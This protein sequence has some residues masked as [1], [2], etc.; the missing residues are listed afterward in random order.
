MLSAA[1]CILVYSDEQLAKTEDC[2]N[3]GYDLRQ[4]NATRRQQ[5]GDLQSLA[6]EPTKR[7]PLRIQPPPTPGL[8]IQVSVTVKYNS[9][10]SVHQTQQN[11]WSSCPWTHPNEDCHW[12]IS[13]S[14]M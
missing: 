1:A 11:V 2:G 9:A 3:V 5:P 8:Q 6:A 14:T 7:D 4:K 12:E 13:G 10:L